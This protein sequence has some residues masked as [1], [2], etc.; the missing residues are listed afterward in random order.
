M[1]FFLHKII[2]GYCKVKFH[3]KWCEIYGDY[4]K[5][6]LE[7]MKFHEKRGRG[8]RIIWEK[9]AA[10]RLYIGMLQKPNASL[11]KHV[12]RGT[13]YLMLALGSSTFQSFLH[14][15]MWIYQHLSTRILTVNPLHFYIWKT[16]S[17]S[18]IWKRN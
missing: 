1:F 2:P 13:Q 7:A 16:L 11:D 14:Y 3:V 4:F 17:Q 15:F 6:W 12:L 8:Q 5:L 18:K 9:Y 10:S